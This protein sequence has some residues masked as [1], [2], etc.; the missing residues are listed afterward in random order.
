MA[1]PK[2]PFQSVR[3]RNLSTAITDSVLVE[4]LGLQDEVRSKSRVDVYPME[5]GMC[6]AV[7]TIPEPVP[8]IL[9]KRSITLQGTD[10]VVDEDFEGFTPLSSIPC[11]GSYAE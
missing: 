6:T 2:V 1:S 11:S 7:L 10:Y 9:A 5:V 3:V 8:P 4:E